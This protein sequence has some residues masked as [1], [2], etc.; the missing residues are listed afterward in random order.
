MSNIQLHQHS[1]ES[2]ESETQTWKT[3][4][5]AEKQATYFKKLISF[6]DESRANGKIIYPE[7]SDIFS[8]LRLTAFEDVKVVILGQDP[9]HGPNQAHGLCFSVREGIQPPPSLINIFKELKNDV[10]VTS[11][12]HGYLEK[13]A[14]QGVLL[15][16]AVLTVEDGKAAA[17]AG[18]GWEQFTDKIISELNE[19]KKGIIFLLWGS[20]AQKKGQFIDRAKHHVLAAPHPSPLSAHR[21]FFGCKHFSKTNEILK[22]LGKNSIDWQL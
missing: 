16:N 14:K 21:G 19:R 22:S 3:V 6:V 5:S 7:N 1:T 8:A 9:Y 12:N 4:L 10:G 17:H 13:W 20:Y 15:L 18:L 11:P 2:D